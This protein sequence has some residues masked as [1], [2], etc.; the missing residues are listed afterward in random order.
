[1]WCFIS[2]VLG[3]LIVYITITQPKH[4]DGFDTFHIFKVLG[5][6]RLF[7]NLFGDKK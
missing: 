7:G 4:K 5:L 3:Y 6:T 1:M 2:L